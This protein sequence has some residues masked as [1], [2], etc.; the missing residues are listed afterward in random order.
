LYDDFPADFFAISV[1]FN[2]SGKFRR[3]L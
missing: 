3:C 1:F 2:I